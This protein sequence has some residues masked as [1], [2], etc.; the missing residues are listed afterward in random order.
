MVR[1]APGDE[2]DRCPPASAIGGS[3]DH[4]PAC[5]STTAT[6]CVVAYSTFD[7]TPPANSRF[8]RVGSSINP[9][10]P[11]KPGLEV[12]CVNPAAPGSTRG[13]ALRPYFSGSAPVKTPWVTYPGLYKAR[14]KQADGA[15]WLQVT[16]RSGDSRPIVAENLGPAWGLHIYDVNLA[17]GNLVALVGAQSAA[18]SARR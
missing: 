6:G 9:F 14:C 11:T 15:S 17:L 4:I 1:P 8:G 16:H 10:E 12:L 13:A 3:F 2:R 18:Y 7:H 5:D